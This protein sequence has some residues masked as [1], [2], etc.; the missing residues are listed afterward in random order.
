M[1]ESP[2]INPK[3]PVLW[4]GGDYNPEQW[5][6]EIWDED[7]RLMAEARFRVATLGVFSWVS[8]QPKEGQ[9]E[10][11]WLDGVI[12][13][14]TASDRYFILA[15]P[16][17]AP[18]AWMSRKYPETLRTG[19]DGVRRKHGNRVN[20]NLN[21]P[22]Y[23][24]KCRE[25]ARRLAERYGAHPRLLAWHVSNEYSGNADYSDLS[26][27]AFR[28]WLQR[29]FGDL[30][31]LNR[32]YWTPFWGHT[33]GDWEEIDPPGGPYG[34]T[35]I[36]GLTVDW[37]RFTTDAT[38]EFMLNEAAPLREISPEVPITTN[39]MGAYPPLNY[40]KL[41]PHI[42]FVSWDSYPDFGQ[43]PIGHHDW[44]KT[45]FKHDLMRSLKPDRPWLLM[46]MAPGASNWQ[47]FMTP[48]R[49]GVHLFESLQAVAHGADGVQYF[50]W[51]AS[52]GSQEQLHAAVVGHN[53]GA[54][55]R[56]FQEV[57]EVGRRLDELEV[58][59]KRSESRVAVVFDWENLW[60][61]DAAC[62][63]IQGDKGYYETCVA[64][65]AA[66]WKAG[67]GVDLVGMD[68]DLSRYSLL[69][70][71]MAYSV[72]QSFA[73]RVE[74][75]VAGGGTMLTTYLSGWTDENSLVFEG[76]FLAPWKEML[77]IWSEELDVLRGGAT[78]AFSNGA[79]AGP[80]CELVHADEAEVL[81]TYS[82]EFYVGRPAMTVNRHGRGKAYYVAARVNQEFLDGFLP[83]LAREA[84]VEPVY[85]GDLPRGV[86]AQRRGDRLFFLN[87]TEQTVKIEGET[88]GPYGVLVR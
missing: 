87:P 82:D 24:E 12:E 21:S 20:Y 2:F 26:A 53:G 35:A 81:A 4:H 78:V 49:P 75:F 66:F 11:D 36:Q 39:L 88:L 44:I 68:D 29:K 14:L 16:S 7:M 40:R 54:K 23:Q 62:G 18:P 52:R 80:F 69:I 32:A 13:R 41:A 73:Q 28:L 15:T 83:Q 48:K 38:V 46:E 51:R 84:G 5:P 43:V 76:G 10:F 9:Y 47:P 86:T 45:S 50:Q 25:I 74:A 65:Y 30:D 67:I 42:D 37:K 60:A 31:S 56:M 58:V 17:A 59:G 8:L 19:S 27:A 33:Y 57:A 61:I 70:A 79:T 85:E 1:A 77:G 64:H 34:E 22:V 72:G 63:P 3:L 55:A 6:P 71:P